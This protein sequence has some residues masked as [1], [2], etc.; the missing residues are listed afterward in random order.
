MKVISSIQL[1][2][3]TTGAILVEV[4]AIGQPGKVAIT[5]C[6]AGRVPL[7]KAEIRATLIS[8]LELFKED[9]ADEVGK[10]DPDEGQSHAAE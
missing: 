9:A 8:A 7:N 3:D 10:P 4:H 2:P 6:N 1:S 5:A